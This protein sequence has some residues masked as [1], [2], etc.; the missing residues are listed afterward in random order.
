[1]QADVRRLRPK[2]DAK[3]ENL[4]GELGII[5]L[6]VATTS[7]GRL[8]KSVSPEETDIYVRH[9][10]IAGPCY[11]VSMAAGSRNRNLRNEVRPNTSSVPRK[12]LR[13]MFGL[14]LDCWKSFRSCTNRCCIRLFKNAVTNEASLR[15]VSGKPGTNLPCE[16]QANLYSCD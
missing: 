10:P 7:E 13:H 5:L 9:D 12:H 11:F 16:T 4:T 6:K 15:T 8:P 1:T 2:L 3:I 14:F